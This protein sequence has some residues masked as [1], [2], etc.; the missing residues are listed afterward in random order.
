MKM[1]NVSK[2]LGA[3]HNKIKK[4]AKSLRKREERGEKTVI[5]ILKAVNQVWKEKMTEG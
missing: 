2:A 1:E 5:L 3:R 4:E